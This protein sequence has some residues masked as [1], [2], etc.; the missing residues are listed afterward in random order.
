MATLRYNKK[1]EDYDEHELFEVTIGEKVWVDE[2]PVADEDDEPY[3][4]L[5]DETLPCI[6]IADGADYPGLKE[7]TVYRLVEVPTERLADG[8]DIV[9]E[10]DDAGD[11][12]PI[13]P[14]DLN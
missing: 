8:E 12:D 9:L 5:F 7:N 4:L 6:L 10:D 2:T 11:D 14:G 1:S 3:I 13:I